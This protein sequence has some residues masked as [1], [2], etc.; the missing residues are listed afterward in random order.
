MNL[1][2]RNQQLLATEGVY[3]LNIWS[4][5]LEGAEGMIFVLEWQYDQHLLYVVYM[6][7]F[8]I[9]LFQLKIQCVMAFTIFLSLF[10]FFFF[11]FHVSITIAD[12]KKNKL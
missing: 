4:S 5:F 6:M 3:L 1:L 12:T 10:K 8:M 2:S 11:F 9:F 7:K